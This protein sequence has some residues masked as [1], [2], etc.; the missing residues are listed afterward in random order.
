MTYAIWDSTLET[1]NELVDSEHKQLFAIINELHD[2]IVERHD[3]RVQ[4]D[5]LVRLMMYARDHFTHEEELMRSIFYPGLVD[6]KRMHKE[7]SEEATILAAEY[8][9]SE[10]LLP[11]TLA[12]FL[13]DWLVKHIRIEDRK[14]GEFIREKARSQ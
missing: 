10:K 8:H 6:Q 4:D 2:S 11:I 9:S 7:F 13:H 1:G 5:I 14:I 12:M 3:R